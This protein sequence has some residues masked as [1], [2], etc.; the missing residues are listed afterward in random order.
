MDR[1]AV[2]HP[3]M[4]VCHRT[5]KNGTQT[6]KGVSPNSLVGEIKMMSKMTIRIS[7]PNIASAALLS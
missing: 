4:R 3:R 2:P 7:A 5:P 6:G 1:K